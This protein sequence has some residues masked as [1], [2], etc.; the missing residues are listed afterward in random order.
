MTRRERMEQRQER[1]EA[2]AQ[3]RETS[4]RG[5]FDQAHTM[6]DAIPFG[7]PILVSRTVN[8][9]VKYVMLWHAKN[10]TAQA[11]VGVD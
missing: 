11:G 1:R 5:A 4:A 10:W 3:K 9:L 6:A 8:S 2:W 7:Q